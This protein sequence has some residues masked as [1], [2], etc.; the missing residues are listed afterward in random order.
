MIAV[1]DYGMGTLRSVQK[2]LQHVGGDAQIVTSPIDVDRAEKVVLPGVGAF[3]DAIDM[4]RKTGLDEAVIRAVHKG[5]P[6]LGICLGFQ[7]LFDV[8]YED[9]QHTGLGLLPGKVIRFDFPTNIVAQPL[10]IPHIGWNQICTKPGCPLF[11]GV[12][13]ESYV[14]F[15]HSYH[16]VTLNNEVIAATT[17]YGYGFPSAVWS[18]K[19]FA[20]QFHPEKSQA[21]GQQMLKNFV[22]M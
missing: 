16:A 15:V 8:S 13:N 22:D 17:D 20:T 18:D 11:R 10:K 9:G 21:V 3:K 2:A 1:V 14:Y 5:S 4:L 19:I 12:E 6:F 7:L